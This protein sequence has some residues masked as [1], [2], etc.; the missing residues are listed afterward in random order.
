MN[1]DDTTVA[2]TTATVEEIP[3]EPIVEAHIL[4]PVQDASSSHEMSVPEDIIYQDF[5]VEPS[6]HHTSNALV[7]NLEPKDNHPAHTR[8]SSRSN[9]E[10][11][12][13]VLFAVLLSVTSCYWVFSVLSKSPWARKFL[14]VPQRYFLALA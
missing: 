1:T 7:Q 10:E 8:Q 3:D 9:W 11:N 14:P 4:E 12:E 2:A 13:R 5:Q 6:F